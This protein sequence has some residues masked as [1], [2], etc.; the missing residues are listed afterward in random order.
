MTRRRL[1]LDIVGVLLAASLLFAIA[2]ISRP[3]AVAAAS[4]AAANDACP[5]P[6]SSFES[7]CYLGP[8]ADVLGFIAEDGDIDIYRVEPL[9]FGVRVHV[10][11]VE[12]PANLRLTLLDWA[13]SVLARSEPGSPG[14][15]VTLGPPG[16]YY[17]AVEQVSRGPVDPTAPYR[18]ASQLSYPGP[19]PQVAYSATFRP[20]GDEVDDFDTSSDGIAD[21]E[22]SQGR[23]YIKMKR[24]GDAD[25]PAEAGQWLPL[26]D[27]V[28]GFTL[29]LDVRQVDQSDSGFL[30]QFRSPEDAGA[31]A[32]YGLLVSP[33][34]QRFHLYVYDEDEDV[35]RGLKNWT[36]N[37]A[38]QPTG[39]NRVVIRCHGDDIIV[40]INGTEIAHVKDTTYHDGLIWFAAM[41]WSPQ[42]S[43]VT[44]SNIL[45][46]VP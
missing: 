16:S 29:S 31:E 19:T 35:T 40:N 46:T 1:P 4:P 7:T 24:G 12:L 44:F 8:N 33:T 45:V 43:V 38:I 5:E 41:A 34:E 42:P 30:V 28:S 37:S 21:Y 26:D 13:A 20:G 2:G 23:M 15:D 39:P 18:L 14:L 17:I 32:G 27:S 3:A 9:E 10:A 25:D 36:K 22:I 11:L 6:N